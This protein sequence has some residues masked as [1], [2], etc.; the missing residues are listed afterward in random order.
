MAGQTINLLQNF[1]DRRLREADRDRAGGKIAVTGSPLNVVQAG[2]SPF[3]RPLGMDVMA[4]QGGAEETE[5]REANLPDN[6]AI[7]LSGGFVRGDVDSLP[8]F[9]QDTE[10]EG[11]YVSG[12]VEFYPGENTMLG[13]SGYIGSLDADTPLGQQVE[14]DT[15][16]VSLYGR[17][18]FAGG[19][20]LDAQVAMGS[21]GFDT[22]RTVDFVGGPQTLTSSSDDLLVS[23]AIAL[24]Y[25]LETGIGTFS[26]GIEGRYASVDLGVVRENGGNTALTI[27]RESFT[28]TQIRTGFDYEKQTEMVRI[29]ANAQ[30][31]WELDDGPQLLAANFAQGVGPNAN[32]VLDQADETW[33]EL[34]VS[35]TVGDGPFQIGVGFDTTIGRDSANARVVSGTATY[36]F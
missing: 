1:N 33:V 16:A 24:S 30:V 9:T 13:L 12:G 15:Y 20:V 4:L 25:D 3:G 5:M 35:A 14:S 27:A 17:H 22:T 7:F 10:T 2:L 29:N 28:S 31:A 26:P 32:F 18:K 19:A 6:V 11:H 8:G 36:R 21:M 34:G 23:G